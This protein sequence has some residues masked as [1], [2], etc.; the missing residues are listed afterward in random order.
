MRK[1]ILSIIA[2][3]VY[4]VFYG[5]TVAELYD[6]KDYEALTKLEDKADALTGEELCQVGFA[7]FQ[8]EKDDKAVSFYDKAIAKGFDNAPTHFYKGIALTFLRKYQ[9]A[10]IEVDMALKKEPNNQEYMNQKGLIYKFQGKE[11]KALDYFEEA[12]RFPNTFG[13]PFFWVA[14]IYHGNQEYE[15][16]LKLY[17]VAAEKVPKQNTYYVNTLLCIGQLEYTYTQNYQKSAKAYAEAIALR[18]KD[19]ENYPKLI[20][21]YNAAKE[22]AKADAVF[23][24]MKTAYKNNELP[25]ELMKSNTVAV[26]ELEYNKQKLTIYKALEDPKEVLDVTYKIKLFNPGGDKVAREFTVE[27]T[28]QVANGFKHLLSEVKGE[29]HFTYPYGWKTDAIP[30]E[31][32]K[33]AITQVL[34]GS[35]QKMATDK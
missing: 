24:L 15:K 6:H 25:K 9:D 14:Y 10:L 35:L 20:K 12:T 2:V 1:I 34:D 18:P 28:I 11:D 22:Y 27:K 23:D 30:L 21:A 16:A 26:D 13:E 7:F 33:K 5:Q 19:Y 8:L 31:D 32:V 17:Y 4:P 3:F 29:A